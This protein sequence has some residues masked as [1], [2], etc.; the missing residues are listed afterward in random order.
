M[1]QQEFLTKLVRWLESGRI[2]YYLTGSLASSIHGE[3]RATHD[4]DLVVS[5]SPEAV[6]ELAAAF[7]FPPYYLDENAALEA[8]RL[9][10]SF[11][12]IDSGTGIKADVWIAGDDDYGRSAMARRVRVENPYGALWVASPEDSILAKLN[13]VRMLGGSEQQMRDVRRVFEVSFPLLDQAHLDKWAAAL[14][15]AD[16]LAVTR[17]EARPD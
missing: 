13:W 14:G 4:I 12:L 2:E 9:K 8:I 10:R 6:R 17:A 3:P 16:L 15:V 5:M 7:P 1:S 11:N